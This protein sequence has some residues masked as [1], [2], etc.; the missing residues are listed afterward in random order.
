MTTIA[1]SWPERAIACDSRLT[2]GDQK[3]AVKKVYRIK[4]TLYG[5]SGTVDKDWDGLIA[6]LRD[7][8]KPKPSMKNLSVLA[9]SERG[10]FWVND[11]IELEPISAPFAA[12]GSG[13]HAALGALKAGADLKKAVCIAC[14]IDSSS[15]KPVRLYRL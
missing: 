15:E 9:L 3:Y 7:P 11:K 10:V 6:H 5:L 8:R 13:A 12:K 4:G 1:V 14:E 2:W